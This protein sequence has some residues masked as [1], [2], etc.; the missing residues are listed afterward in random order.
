LAIQ[1]VSLSGGPPV[2]VLDSAVGGAVAWGPDDHLYFLHPTEPEVYRVSAAGGRPELVTRLQGPAGAAYDWPAI[3]PNGKGII[4]TVGP[5][6]TSTTPGTST[7]D[8]LSVQ[9]FDLETGASR[10]AVTGA[11]GRYAPTGHL[12]YATLDRV[13]LAAPF[14]QG[15]LAFTGRPVAMLEGVDVRSE[16][17]TDLALSPTGTLVYTTL[18]FNAPE[19]VSWVGGDGSVTRVDPAW[20]RDWEFE[21]LAL[22]PD[23][24]RAAIGIETGNRGD[25]WIKQLDRGPLSRLTF[26]GDYNGSPTWTADGRF[27]TYVSL[28]KGGRAVRRVAADGSGGDSLL[29]ELDRDIHYAESS[30]DGHWLVVSVGGRSDDVLALRVGQDTLPQPVLAEAFDEFL[31]ALSPDGRWLAYV[32]N[33]SGR[34]EVY[35]RPFPDTRSGKWQLTTDGGTEPI[36]GAGGRQLFLRGLDRT[37]ILGVDLARGPGSAAQ[38][39]VVRLPASDDFEGNPRNRLFDAAAGGRFLMIQ[40]ANATDVSGDLVVVL[41]WFTELRAKVGR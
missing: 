8:R 2:T 4:L 17:I 23:G 41:N 3:L 28:Q 27:V 13:L 14:D 20:T 25:V 24:R 1:V 35:L 32:S 33:E 26:A 12:V 22:S 38:R 19:A 18:S 30:R 34:N 39:V 16:G 7:G 11:F 9:A 37:A 36:W 31:P 10:G 15:S 5:R 21:G 29:L 40:R 6:R